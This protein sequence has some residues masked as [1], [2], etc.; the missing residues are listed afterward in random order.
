[1]NMLVLPQEVLIEVDSRDACYWEGKGYD[2][3]RKINRDKKIVVPKGTRILVNVLDLPLGSGITIKVKCDYC[4][5]VIDKTYVN[6]LKSKNNC[7]TNKDC[8]EHC[9]S[10]KTLESRFIYTAEMAVEIFKKANLKINIKEYVDANSSISYKCMVCGHESSNSLT[11]I[12]SGSRCAK[13]KI[14]ECAEDKRLSYKDVQ[15]CFEEGGCVLL[16]VEYINFHSLLDYICECGNPSKI[17]LSSFKKGARCEKCASKKRSE[18]SRTPFEE[19]KEIFKN[20]GCVLISTEYINNGTILDYLCECGR[21]SKITLRK[22]QSGGRCKRCKQEKT[23]ERCK[24]PIEYVRQTFLDCGCKLLSDTYNNTHQTL[25]FQCSCGNVSTIT[26]TQLQMGV[27]CED[28]EENGTPLTRRSSGRARFTD[29]YTEWRRSILERDNYTCQCCGQKGGKLNI[30]HLDGYNWCVEKR[31]DIENGVA[32][33]ISDHK[34]FHDKYGRG[35]NTREQYE[36]WIKIK[37]E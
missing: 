25:D 32:L 8:C 21:P 14:K 7:N 16:S 34:D 27:R 5:E 17:S 22:F 10:K 12:V 37:N 33:C 31:F 2:I 36:E 15:K 6:Y 30:H 3:P 18:S 29:E 35:N 23:R 13:C 1:M 4:L 28:C 9:T 26:F 19:V 11:G 20:G 24:H